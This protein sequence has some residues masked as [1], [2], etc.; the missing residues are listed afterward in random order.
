VPSKKIIP[1]ILSC[2]LVLGG[3][4]FILKKTESNIAITSQGRSPLQPVQRNVIET[5]DSDG[6]GLAD[7][8]ESLWKT[9]TMRTD[10]DSD[11]I[12]DGDE[13]AQ[14]RDPAQ[15]G[16]GESE[17]VAQ[18]RAQVSGVEDGNPNITQKVA[19]QVFERYIAEKNAGVQ[20][21]VDFNDLAGDIMQSYETRVYADTYTSGNITIVDTTD[22]SLRDY[23]NAYTTIIG[24]HQDIYTAQI[25]NHFRIDAA[26]ETITPDVAWFETLAATYD[27]I[28]AKLLTLNTP[29]TLTDK[30]VSAINNLHGIAISL[31]DIAATETDTVRGLQGVQR[32]AALWTSQKVIYSDIASIFTTSGILFTL[33]EPGAAWNAFR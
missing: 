27:Q 22:A 6:D 15:S 11:G 3:L 4:Y 1:I 16:A 26:N 21:T 19:R 8:E 32:Y 2:I 28:V 30:H 29:R 10:S 20:T 12:S 5:T 23:G 17:N 24:Q 18:I 13:V 14:G 33:N 25:Q 9:S 31:R 7:W